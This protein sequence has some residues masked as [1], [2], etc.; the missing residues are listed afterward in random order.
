MILSTVVNLSKCPFHQNGKVVASKKQKHHEHKHEHAHCDCCEH[1]HNHEHDEKCNNCTKYEN[2][3][4]ENKEL[5][6]NMAIDEY[7]FENIDCPNCALK[8]E[9]ALNKCNDIIDAKVNFV[10]KKS[11]LH[12]VITLKFMKL[13]VRKL[14]K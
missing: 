9:R 7:M 8:V 13:Y 3:N 5:G 14:R 2:A 4:S 6:P 1:E 10:N 12:I 11:L